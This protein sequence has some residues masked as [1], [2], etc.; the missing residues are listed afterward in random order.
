[1]GCIF[2]VFYSSLLDMK[3][4]EIAAT[5]TTRT[6]EHRTDPSTT[7]LTT[8][9]TEALKG[10][11]PTGDHPNLLWTPRPGLILLMVEAVDTTHLTIITHS[12]H[13]EVNIQEVVASTRPTV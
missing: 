10:G 3:W 7:D 11:R 12:D 6:K 4:A 8:H 1:M 9:H 13:M 2:R 5:T